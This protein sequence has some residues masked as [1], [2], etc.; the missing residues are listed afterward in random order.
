MGL[1]MSLKK[2]LKLEGDGFGDEFEFLKEIGLQLGGDR[3]K[4]GL[5]LGR[6]GSRV[7]GRGYGD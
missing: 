5:E 1:E 2:G 4:M 3:F 7:Q 6:D